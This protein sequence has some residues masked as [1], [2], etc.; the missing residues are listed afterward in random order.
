MRPLKQGQPP[1]AAAGVQEVTRTEQPG[2]APG[3]SRCCLDPSSRGPLQ[4]KSSRLGRQMVSSKPE[5]AGLSCKHP[6]TPAW[7]CSHSR[8]PLR[9]DNPGGR[10]RVATDLEGEKEE[11][12]TEHTGPGTHGTDAPRRYPAGGQC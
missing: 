1:N 10:T 6:A 7:Q 2:K 8:C 4:G 5:T 9:R 11:V 12:Q 3:A